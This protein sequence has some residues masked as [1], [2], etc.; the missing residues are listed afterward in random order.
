MTVVERE[1]QPF[2]DVGRRNVMQELL[3]VPLLVR[4]LGLPRGGS[5]LEVGCGRGIALPPLS[6]LL[7]PELLVGIDIDLELLSIARHRVASSGT[8]ATLEQAD[9]RAL[10]FADASFS[11]VI[12]FGTCHH[13]A[14]RG[15]AL[16]EIVRVLEPGGL[17]ACETVCSQLLSHPF[18]TRGRRLPWSLVPELAVERDAILWKARRKRR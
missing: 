8:E 14:R 17:F 6:R 12:D 16:R 10:P 11:L 3:E 9:V 7:A 2:P 5:I 1:Y 4:A 15:N 13:I 18:R